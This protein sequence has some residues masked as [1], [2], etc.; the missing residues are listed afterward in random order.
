MVTAPTPMSRQ[1]FLHGPLRR[2]G[3]GSGGLCGDR[4]LVRVG[5]GIFEWVLILSVKPRTPS[6]G[7]GEA[8]MR[9]WWYLWSSAKRG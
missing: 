8:H 5:K 1:E 6:S 9:G 4:I 3:V 7:C 2:S